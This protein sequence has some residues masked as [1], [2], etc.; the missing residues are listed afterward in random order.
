MTVFGTSA[1]LLPMDDFLSKPNLFDAIYQYMTDISVDLLAVLFFYTDKARGENRRQLM[2]CGTKKKAE[3][4]VEDMTKYLVESDD[5][6]TL[7]IE[8]RRIDDVST[9]AAPGNEQLIVKLFD[10]GNVKA[11]R[12][13]VAP[14]LINF[15]ETSKSML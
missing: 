5:C 7:E 10:Q 8:V 13:Q 1:V 15:F 14:L 6:K 2:L 9:C 4:L 11:S 3:T 12:K